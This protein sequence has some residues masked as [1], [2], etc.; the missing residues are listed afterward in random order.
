MKY[1]RREIGPLLTL[2]GATALS[3]TTAARTVRSSALEQTRPSRPPMD[4]RF[5]MLDL[6]AEYCWCFDCQD[7]ASFA[8]LFTLDGEFQTVG[9]GARGRD[10]IA[11]YIPTLWAQHGDEIWQHHADQLLYFGKGN[12]YTVYSYWSVLKANEQNASVMGFGYYVSHCVKQNGNWLFQK[13]HL[14]RWDRNSLP[15]ATSP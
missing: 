8:S 10:N 15:W 1:S 3:A 12:A 4:D 9:S 13:R 5:G 6:F 11:A 14:H 2:G 7:A